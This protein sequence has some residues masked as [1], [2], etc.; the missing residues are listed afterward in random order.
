MRR[1]VRSLATLAVAIALIPLSTGPAAARSLPRCPWSVSTVV[2]G[3][4]S[5]ENLAFDGL[6]RMLLSRSVSGAGQIY[7]LD[8]TGIGTTVV[9]P[10]DSPGGIVTEGNAAYFTTG[11]SLISGIIGRKDGTVSR[12][13]PVGDELTTVA[14]G[15][16]MP[17]GMARLPDGDFIVSRNLG[18][19]TGLT[20]IAND[21]TP[22]KPWA[23][24]LKHTNGVAYDPTNRR[25]I[26]SLDFSPTATLALIDIDRPAQPT[27]INLGIFGLLGFPD[28]LTVGGDGMIYLAMAGGTI[29][30]V[31]PVNKT[32]CGLA[33]G[34]YGAT[35]VRFGAGP[36][37]DPRALYCTTLSGSV[38]RLTPPNR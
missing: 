35:S 6:G 25:I 20:R 1:L 4:G 37:W 24:S 5:L 17:N 33:A 7:R 16:T 27:T 15:L 13:D 12:L 36:G 38:Y 30:G 3:M 26:T 9:N 34:L 8:P 14:S 23:T 28:D 21:G 18:A 11:N 32:A 10:I 29:V 22:S 31:D 2:T 19:T